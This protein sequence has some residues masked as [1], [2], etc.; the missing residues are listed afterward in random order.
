M[1]NCSPGDD[2][3]L[4]TRCLD[5]N[6]RQHLLLRHFHQPICYVNFTMVLNIPISMFFILCVCPWNIS[7]S[8]MTWV[9]GSSVVSRWTE[10]SNI[11]LPVENEFMPSEILCCGNGYN[12]CVC[13]HRA[14]AQDCLLMR[15]QIHPLP[16]FLLLLSS[17]LP[18]LWISPRRFTISRCLLKDV[19]SDVIG[20]ILMCL[21][22]K[23][24]GPN[25]I[26][27]FVAAKE[28]TQG[29]WW[30]TGG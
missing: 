28:V 8:D 3:S 13:I 19:N 18:S 24:F 22:C 26:C 1:G 20:Y 25:K 4:W 11:E 15:N 27:S 16:L 14:I 17:S 12:N 6:T 9:K 5:W 30:S 23:C 21:Q 10:C 7:I 29:H 2:M